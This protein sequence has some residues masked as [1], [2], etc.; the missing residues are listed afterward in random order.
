MQKID[1]NVLL[2]YVLNDHAELSQSARE[3]IDQQIVEVPIEVLSEVVYVLTG[4]YA[5]ARQAV[6]AELKNYESSL[7]N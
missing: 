4:Y 3:M 1:A 6:C 2:R 7:Q 5:I